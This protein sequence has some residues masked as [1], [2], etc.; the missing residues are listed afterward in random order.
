MEQ[1]PTPNLEQQRRETLAQ[2]HEA[3]S[4]FE[5]EG[6]PYAAMLAAQLLLAIESLPPE[7]LTDTNLTLNFTLSNPGGAI[8]P[9]K[10]QAVAS[11]VH[12]YAART[13]KRLLL[14]EKELLSGKAELV[15]IA[16]TL[17][18]PETADMP[19]PVAASE[20]PVSPTDPEFARTIQ[21]GFLKTLE[22]QTDMEKI[23]PKLGL[24]DDEDGP[25]K[26][27]VA[28]RLESTPTREQT[29][30]R[31]IKK[32]IDELDFDRVVEQAASLSPLYRESVRAD[33]I[34]QMAHKFITHSHS[35]DEAQLAL[36]IRQLAQLNVTYEP[37]PAPGEK[38]T[39][40]QEIVF[41][42]IWSIVEQ[43]SVATSKDAALDLVAQ[44]PVATGF[45]RQFHYWANQKVDWRK[46]RVPA[47][48]NKMRVIPQKIW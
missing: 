16:A 7:R 6:Q 43:L 41:T 9:L 34:W 20:P 26:Q 25:A 23:L 38:T 3:L 19:V 33:V 29:I 32:A 18:K 15:L 11:V 12:K 40:G 14:D 2:I 5:G 4:N 39:Q 37:K 1:T 47:L 22:G 48:I 28:D 35:M 27:E 31:E 46:R 24:L 8:D 30:F 42:N 45:R 13:F 36:K 21:L 44:L 17:R 10:V